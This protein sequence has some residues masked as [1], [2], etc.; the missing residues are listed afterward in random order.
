MLSVRKVDES[1]EEKVEGEQVPSDVHK[2]KREGLPEEIWKVCEEYANIFPSDLRKGL[3][4]KRLGYKFK[5]DLE[6]HTKLVHRPIYKLSPLNLDEAKK[7]IEYMLEH[8]FIRPSELPW[9]APVLFA[10][11][12]EGAFSFALTIVGS[13]R[14]RSGIGTHYHYLRR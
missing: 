13:I 5:I 1:A 11:K 12:K 14:R 3:P 4:P 8:G 9:G 10:P 7:Q 6:P 2:I